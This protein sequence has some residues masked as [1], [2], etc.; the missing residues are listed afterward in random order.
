MTASGSAPLAAALEVDP[1]TSLAVHFGMLLGVA[2]FQVLAA[3]PRGKLALHQAWQHGKGVAWGYPVRVDAA[4]AELVVGPGLATD[5]LGREVAS[6]VD[7]CLDVPAWLDQQVAAKAVV[8][9]GD[10]LRRT[11]DAQLVLRHEACL[12]RPVPTVGSTC[13]QGTE[14]P[15]FSRVRELA[16]LDLRPYTTRPCPPPDP[17]APLRALVRDGTLPTGVEPSGSRLTDLRAVAARVVAALG[18]PG[19]LPPHPAGSTRLFPEDEPGEIVLADLPGLT[20]VAE[21]GRWRLEAPTVD[22]SV[23]RVHVPPQVIAELLAELAGCCGCGDDAT[24]AGG[25]RVVCIERSGRSVVVELDGPV[26]PGTVG[27][28]LELRSFDASAAEPAWSDPAVVTVTFDDP[29]TLRFDLPTPPTADLSHRLVLRGTGPTP[30]VGLV[31]GRPV[32]LA[33]GLGDPPGSISDGHDV[34]HLFRA[35]GSAS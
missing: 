2:D 14:N 23:R 22:L 24:D 5:G 13:G 34:T 15:G 27:P 10:G 18:P 17:F 20:V 19:V 30:L 6:D 35:A 26:V 16:R 29:Q 33:G 25:P 9:R 28:A 7:Q 12:T 8:P 11:V 4:A 3:N 31:D 32:P 1:F 21:T